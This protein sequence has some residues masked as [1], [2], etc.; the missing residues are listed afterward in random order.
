MPPRVRSKENMMRQ[1]VAAVM[2]RRRQSDAAS[3]K[4]FGFFGQLACVH[5]AFCA[6]EGAELVMHQRPSGRGA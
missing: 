3:P 4:A 2:N 1:R 5:E 6:L